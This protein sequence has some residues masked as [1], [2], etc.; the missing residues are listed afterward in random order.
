MS[1]ALGTVKK[2][3]PQVTDVVD[4]TKAAQIQVTAG[5]VRA[6][7]R[8]KHAECAMAVACRRVTKC[9]GVIMSLSTAYLITG[10]KA[11]RYEVPP[12][13]TKEIIAFDRGAS[14]EPGVYKLHKPYHEL[15]RENHGNG[16]RDKKSGPVRAYHVTENVRASINSD[17]VR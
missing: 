14:F 12:S 16:S 4:A 1:S 11:T 15:G 5:D 8:K 2:Y 6:S 9:D 3:F 10:T 17:S 7:K 13:I